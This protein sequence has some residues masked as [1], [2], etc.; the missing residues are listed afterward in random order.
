[1]ISDDSIDWW[2]AMILLIDDQR[3]T[4]DKNNWTFLLF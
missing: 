4:E 1:M 3:L 2:S